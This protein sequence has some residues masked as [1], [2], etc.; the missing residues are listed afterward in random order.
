ME[1]SQRLFRE[2]RM[3]Y[4][5]TDKSKKARFQRSQTIRVHLRGLS[6]RREA[7]RDEARLDVS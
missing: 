6:Q 5:D 1:V 4:D 7:I 3:R 2:I